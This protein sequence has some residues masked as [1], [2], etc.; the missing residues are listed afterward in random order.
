[1][2]DSIAP[3]L[4]AERL[5]SLSRA[6]AW[7]ASEHGC[8]GAVDTNCVEAKPEEPDE[9]CPYCLM[10]QAAKAIPDLLADATARAQEIQDLKRGQATLLRALE[11]VEAQLA[12]HAQEIEKMTEQLEV[13]RELKAGYIARMDKAEAENT[14][15]LI[16]I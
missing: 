9:W 5:L 1:M 2:T 12:A 16:H 13:A 4:T 15:S 10:G 7:Q 11:S 14:L 6:L 8:Y 3:S